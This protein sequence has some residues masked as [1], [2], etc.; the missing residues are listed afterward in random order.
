M[1][2]TFF[3]SYLQNVETFF[4]KDVT[5][6]ITKRG[7]RAVRKERSIRQSAKVCI[8][9][10]YSRAFEEILLLAINSYK[11]ILSTFSWKVGG[12]R[13]LTRIVS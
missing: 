8:T 11:S 13:S 6:V 3:M 12:R 4:S 5:C 1:Q 9:N 2:S 7:S 10:Y